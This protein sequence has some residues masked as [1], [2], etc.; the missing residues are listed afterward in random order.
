MK[1]ETSKV[2]QVVQL[3]VEGLGIR[4]T[5]RISGLDQ[6]TVLKILETVGEQCAEMLDQ[7]IR[8]LQPEP[9]EVDE[10]WTMVEHKRRLGNTPT[11]GDFYALLASGKET[12]LIASWFVGKRNQESAD[13]FTSD[14]VTVSEASRKLL[15]TVGVD[16]CGAFSKT[17]TKER[18]TRFRLRNTKAITSEL[19]AEN[20]ATVPETF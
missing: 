20:V 10:C 3:L 11:S 6:K 19:T 5:A 18:T 15:R 16:L 1:I 12:R 13:F 8:G 2:A 17:R 14:C 4:S 7:K 9:V